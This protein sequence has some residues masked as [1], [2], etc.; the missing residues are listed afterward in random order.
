M[1]RTTAWLP[2]GVVTTVLWLAPVEAVPEEA[3]QAPPKQ[4]RAM[5]LAVDYAIVQDSLTG[6]KQRE[7]WQRIAADALQA[8]LPGVLADRAGMDVVGRPSLEAG[9]AVALDEHAALAGLVLRVRETLDGSAWHTR[10]ESFDH[11]IG[12]GLAFLGARA[13]AGYGVVLTGWQVEH[14]PGAVV[15]SLVLNVAGVIMVPFAGNRLLAGVFDLASGQLLWSDSTSGA[16][17]LGVGSPDLRDAESA[18]KALARVF[19]SFAAPR[20]EEPAP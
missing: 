18:R 9:E 15:T 4:P 2:A 20:V 6:L 12:T 10:K 19:E 7:D 17:V 3:P 14:S 11:G 1:R 13:G 5:L 8:A 16:E